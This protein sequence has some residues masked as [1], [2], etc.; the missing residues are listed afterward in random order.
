MLS[1]VLRSELRR[2]TRLRFCLKSVCHLTGKQTGLFLQSGVWGPPGT[3]RHSSG[4]EDARLG[5]GVQGCFLRAETPELGSGN[6]RTASRWRKMEK[7]FQAAQP[8]RAKAQARLRCVQEAG[9]GLTGPDGLWKVE[10]DE[11]RPRAWQ[12]S[13]QGG[14][15]SH[16][17]VG[18]GHLGTGVGRKAA[19]RAGFQEDPWTAVWRMGDSRTLLEV[20]RPA[21]RF[22]A[23]RRGRGYKQ[24]VWRASG[25][26]TLRDTEKMNLT[27]LGDEV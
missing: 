27:R 18:H 17:P 14:S 20:K 25:L 26:A 21:P 22:T 11:V 15:F 16:S 6:T 9:G 13:G 1:T 10:L 24:R 3:G 2:G 12:G 19:R 7:V 5:L 23:S 8:T 4:E